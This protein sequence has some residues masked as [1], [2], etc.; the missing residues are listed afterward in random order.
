MTP[1]G[2]FQDGWIRARLIKHVLTTELNICVS[3]YSDVMVR[4]RGG[5]M[6]GI[7]GINGSGTPSVNSM[8]EALWKYGVPRSCCPSVVASRAVTDAIT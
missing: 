8:G 7:W 5:F 6:W 1:L 2:T 3:V 4:L